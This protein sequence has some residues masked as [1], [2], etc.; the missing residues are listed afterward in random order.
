MASATTTAAAGHLV[1]AALIAT[2]EALRRCRIRQR[3][4]GCHCG[5]K[6]QGD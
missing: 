1:A 4:N 2:V 5:G 3:E 6:E